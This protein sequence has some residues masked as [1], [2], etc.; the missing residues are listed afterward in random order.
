M[1]AS[2]SSV[3]WSECRDEET[4]RSSSSGSSTSTSTTPSSGDRSK[5]GNRSRQSVSEV[6]RQFHLGDGSGDDKADRI[7]QHLGDSSRDG[8]AGR[9][10]QHHLGLSGMSGLPKNGSLAGDWLRGDR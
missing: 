10:H 7:F 1:T 8:Q 2:R 4:S 5:G 9:F 3:R 6:I